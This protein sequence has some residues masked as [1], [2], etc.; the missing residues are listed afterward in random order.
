MTA[1]PGLGVGQ[2]T[3]MKFPRSSLVMQDAEKRAILVTCMLLC[4]AET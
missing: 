4:N 3:F 1:V 2:V